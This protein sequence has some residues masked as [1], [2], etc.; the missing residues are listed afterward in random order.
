MISAVTSLPRDSRRFLRPARS[1]LA[2]LEVIGKTPTPVQLP[3]EAWD[4]CVDLLRLHSEAR[5][6]RWR[7]ATDHLERRLAGSL[8]S[9]IYA[10]RDSARAFTGDTRHR[11]CPALRSLFADITALTGEFDEV[12]FDLREKRLWVVTDPIELDGLALGRFR[13]V[14]LWARLGENRP[15]YLEAL[16]PNEASC[17][18]SVIHPHVRDDALCEG[19]GKSAIR[20]ALESGRVFDFFLLVRQIL[21]TYNSASAYVRIEDWVGVKCVDCGSTTDREEAYT[22][23]RCDSDLCADCTSSCSDCGRSSCSECRSHCHGCESDFCRRCLNDCE[24]C[25]D[26]FCSSC[27]TDGICDPCRETSE[28]P[29]EDLEPVAAEAATIASTDPQ[30]HADGVGEVGLFA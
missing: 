2:Q 18:S 8:D 24:D 4:S 11:A 7:I 5:E 9:L 26:A 1:I 16:D 20:A 23:E 22:C 28:E 25:G 15:Y 30:V 14:L 6:R 13:I 27:L 19:D 3:Q 10:V 21:E 29:D 17:D 12:E